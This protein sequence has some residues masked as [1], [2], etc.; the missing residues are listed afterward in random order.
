MSLTK[1]EYF[2]DPSEFKKGLKGVIGKRGV[3]MIGDTNVG[4]NPLPPSVVPEITLLSS[5]A[6]RPFKEGPIQWN[7]W[8]DHGKIFDSAGAWSE[9]SE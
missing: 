6:I 5:G 7:D 1:K 2:D 9:P 3:K 4:P 8:K